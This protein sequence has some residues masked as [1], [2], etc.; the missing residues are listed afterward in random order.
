MLP[1]GSYGHELPVRMDISSMFPM[2]FDP[3][4]PRDLPDGS[5]PA[6]YRSRSEC[7]PT[8]YFSH[9]YYSRLEDVHRIPP[10]PGFPTEQR[11]L[12]SMSKA[13]QDMRNANVFLDSHH[14]VS[15]L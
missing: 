4:Q 12:G 3:T 10:P 6:P 1:S 8:Y 15:V 11:F 5:G 14:V 2:S 9:L 7:K 13:A